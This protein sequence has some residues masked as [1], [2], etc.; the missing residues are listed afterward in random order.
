M[1]H[2]HLLLSWCSHYFLCLCSWPITRDEWSIN[3]WRVTTVTDIFLILLWIVRTRETYVS[4]SNSLCLYLCLCHILQYLLT[5]ASWLTMS[6]TTT[7][8]KMKYMQARLSVPEGGLV[9]MSTDDVIVENAN[10][11]DFEGTQQQK[12]IRNQTTSN[13]QS[14]PSSCSSHS[15]PGHLDINTKMIG[16][17]ASSAENLVSMTQIPSGSVR[18]SSKK[19]V[20]KRFL[21]LKNS[22]KNKSKDHSVQQSSP[23]S[24]TQFKPG[25]AA[26]AAVKQSD[27]TTKM[28]LVILILF[29][30]T[31]FPSG[32]LALMVGIYGD[33]FQQEVYEPLGEIFDA[34]AL[35]NSSINFIL[36]CLMSRMFRKNFCQIFI[37]A[38]FHRS[39]QLNLVHRRGNE[40]PSQFPNVT[41]ETAATHVP[42]HPLNQHHQI[43]STPIQHPLQPRDRHLVQELQEYPNT[44]SQQQTQ[45][46]QNTSSFV[47]S[48]SSNNNT[49]SSTTTSGVNNYFSKIADSTTTEMK[50]EK[51]DPNSTIEEM[52][53]H[54]HCEQDN[55]E[56]DHHQNREMMKSHPTSASSTKSSLVLDENNH[57]MMKKPDSGKASKFIL[58]PPPKTRRKFNLPSDQQ[59]QT[60]HLSS[61]GNNHNSRS[62]SPSS[63]TFLDQ[64][65]VV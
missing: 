57:S 24:H 19:V 6:M 42:H 52:K 63:T 53:S 40:S 3:T 38:R 2:T 28:L 26:H 25:S 37:P 50:P 8:H 31:E 48:S 9:V 60:N 43:L 12:L 61:T 11:G 17:S 46:H 44:S 39:Y 65:T 32:I 23:G 36:Y 30:I 4:S 21:S 54:H 45:C 58:L 33:V 41:P 27:R 34:L 18:I 29:L 55:L 47:A 59:Q 35:I 13:P 49:T 20:F 62:G 5:I 51:T 16:L 7:I 56:S 15:S 64:T 1:S 22:R 10:G 14:S